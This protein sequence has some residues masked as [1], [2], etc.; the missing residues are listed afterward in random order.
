MLF[1]NESQVAFIED[2]MRERGYL[3]AKEMAGAFQL[4]R[5]NDL[6]W[7]RA[8]HDY[9]MGERSTAIDIMA[10][11]ADA[12]R[13]P[14]RMHSEYL[15]SLF[16]NND[17]AEGRF[18]VDGRAISVHDIRVPM[19]VVG[20]ER[21]HVAPWRSVHKFHFLADADITFV[22]TNGGHNAGVL[23]EPS[24][25]NRH[26][27]M[28]LHRHGDQ[29][30]DPDTWPTSLDRVCARRPQASAGRDEETVLR[31]NKETDQKGGKRRVESGMRAYPS[32]FVHRFR[33]GQVQEPEAD[34]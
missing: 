5:S 27:R 15:R 6:I 8:V 9:L 19:F 13:M 34:K 1:I 23:S 33:A 17:L 18:K 4:L 2:M 14:Y 7:S 29:Y 24:H 21:D 3:D 30:V 31:P 16:L 10:W 28:A 26:F 32:R 22:L 25:R 20:T 11:N 12:T